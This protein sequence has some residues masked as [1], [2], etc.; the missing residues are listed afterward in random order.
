MCEHGQKLILALV[1]FAQVQFP[2]LALGD[3]DDD[4]LQPTV[5]ALSASDLASEVGA[6]LAAETPLADDHFPALEARDLRT[7]ALHFR[8]I[9]D[10]GDRQAQQFL[11]GVAQHR[12]AGGIHVDIGAPRVG[13]EDAVRRL[14]DKPAESRF[15]GSQRGLPA[16]AFGAQAQYA[17]AVAQ[18]FGQYLKQR[19][20]RFVKGVRSPGINSQGA[21]LFV[22]D[23]QRQRDAGGVAAP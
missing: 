11:A 15:A 23:R 12:A 4:G 6:I 17:N 3:V 20:I 8:R 13:D 21:E 18:V 9:E 7:D 16:G 19:H 1:G 5:R 14:L 22:V 10:V 2:G